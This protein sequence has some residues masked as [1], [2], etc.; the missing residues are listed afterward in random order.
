MLTIASLTLHEAVRRRVVPA[1]LVLSLAFIALSA[2][3]FWHITTALADRNGGTIPE[4]ERAGTFSVLT[5]LLAYMFSVVLAVGA[6]FLAAP[7]IAGDAES[8]VLLAMVPRPLRRSDVVLGKWLG[9]ATLLAAYALAV[10][11]LELLVVAALTGYRP[12]HPALALGYLV[13]EALVLLTLALWFSTRLPPIAG[14]ILAL[15]LFGVAWIAGVAGTIGAALGNQ[16]VVDGATVVNLLVPSDVL[17]RGALWSLEPAALAALA[18]SADALG[19]SG[20][21]AVAGP[22]PP[23]LLGWSVLWTAAILG[24]AVFSFQRRDL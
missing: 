24:A 6:A 11:A 1:A 3:G 4:Y 15:G 16:A 17:W 5:M 2:W 18:G 23:A 13:A 21:F 10:G 19:R 20:P 8:G 14:G 7:S 12:P 22:P 9:L